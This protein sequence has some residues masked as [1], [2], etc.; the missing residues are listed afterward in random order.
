MT[1]IKEQQVENAVEKK[2]VTYYKLQ[3]VAD[4]TVKQNM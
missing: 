2:K 4:M 1:L 3:Y